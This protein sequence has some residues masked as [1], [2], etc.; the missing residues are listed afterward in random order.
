L[1]LI[2][3]GNGRTRDSILFDDPMGNDGINSFG[4]TLVNYVDLNTSSSLLD[5]TC[6]QITYNGHQGTDLEILNFYD[7]DEGVPILCSALGTV[8]YRH[9]GEYDRRTEWQNGVTANAVIVSHSDGFE[10]WYWHMRKNSVNV[11]LGDT[12]AIGDTLG[13]VGSSGYSSGPHIH[14]EIQQNGTVDP[15]SG[16][17]QT[18]TS[19][20]LV[21][22]D[23]VL[24]L[25]FEVM[26]H[27]LTTISLDWAMISERPPTKSHVTAPGTIYSW[28]RL[29]NV[30]NS[31]ELTW[32]FYE[33]GCLWNSY[34]FS[35]NDTYSSSWWYI[36]WN[37]PSNSSYFGDWGLKIYRNDSLIAEQ[38]FL[39]NNEPN[40]V[41]VIEDTTL[42]LEINSIFNGSI[43]I[44]NMFMI[45][46]H[47]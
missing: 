19:R 36:Y 22:G 16:E 28:L 33:N 32:D 45:I 24:E 46:L 25:P 21:Q 43:D 11:E 4:K 44:F 27:G 42:T 8:I 10:A 37:L 5:Y 47:Y 38:P 3:Y 9:D 2:G 26:D 41:P 7:M 18:D 34:S 17:C 20:W 14:F 15:F 40:Q 29:R 30:Q 6:G 1:K 23:Y 13:Y 31:D 35:P 12:V 39:Y